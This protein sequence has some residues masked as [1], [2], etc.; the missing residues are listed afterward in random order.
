MPQFTNV[1][2]LSYTGGTVSSNVVTGELQEVLSAAK[3]AVLD[4][5]SLGDDITYAISL[6]NSGA[7]PFTGLTVTDDLGQYETGGQTAVPL[8]YVDGSVR[9]F[10][11]GVLQPAP[12]ATA[13]PPLTVTGLNVPAGGNAVLLY[14]ARVNSFASPES[15]GTITNGA[16][17]TGAGLTAAVEASETVTAADASRLQIT[18]ALDPTVVP[19]NGQLTYTFTIQNFGNQAVDAGDTASLT[20]TFDPQLSNLTASIDGTT[21]TPVTDYT[22][23]ENT[24]LFTTVPGRITVPEATFTQNAD[25]SYTTTPG[26]VTLTVTGTV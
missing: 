6:V 20:D 11:N 2:T 12:T 25:G 4:T 9:Y 23:D 5:Y 16:T 24:G 7:T 21:L 22:Y 13:G 15:G 10:V 18:K 8:T 14:E 3:T 1:A 26:T 19:E 17:V